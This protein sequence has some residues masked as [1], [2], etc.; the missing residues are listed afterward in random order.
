MEKTRIVFCSSKDDEQIEME[1]YINTQ[2]ELYIKIENELDQFSYITLNKL[3]A[4]KFVKHL[5]KE[6]SYMI[7]SEEENG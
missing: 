4:I 1:A 5:K 3:T 2:N 7:E 6:I